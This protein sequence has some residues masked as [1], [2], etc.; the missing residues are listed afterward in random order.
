MAFIKVTQE[1]KDPFN[2]GKILIIKK[3]GLYI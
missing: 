2:R 3:L 1:E